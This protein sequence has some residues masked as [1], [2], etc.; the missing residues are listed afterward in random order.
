MNSNQYVINNNMKKKKNMN[1]NNNVHNI[2][3]HAV[4]IKR[5]SGIHASVRVQTHT[6][7]HAHRLTH[8]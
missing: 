8:T 1:N 2:H 6:R 4:H 5:H 7:T 3:L